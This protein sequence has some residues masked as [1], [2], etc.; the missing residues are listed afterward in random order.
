MEDA[1]LESHMRSK[2]EKAGVN[3]IY[4]E[5]LWYLRLP[6]KNSLSRNKRE[7]NKENTLRMGSLGRSMHTRLAEAGTC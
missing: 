2:Q 5:M 1:I 6:S 7:K 3:N 4:V